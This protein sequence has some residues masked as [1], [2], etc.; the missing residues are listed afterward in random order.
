MKKRFVTIGIFAILIFTG[1]S[2]CTG[3]HGVPPNLLTISELTLHPENY[4]NQTIRIKGTYAPYD[5]YHWVG[6]ASFISVGLAENT[7]GM[8]QLDFSQITQPEVVEGNFYSFTGK[9]VKDIKFLKE[10]SVYWLEV[11]TVERST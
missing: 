11:A 1:L 9:F 2:G 10:P 8:I 5:Y 7:D 6:N 3:N 4:V